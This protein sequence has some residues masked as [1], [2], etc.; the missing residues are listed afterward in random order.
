MGARV[1]E[2]VEVAEGDEAP[3]DVG[4]RLVGVEGGLRDVLAEEGGKLE[5]EGHDVTSRSKQSERGE[6]NCCPIICW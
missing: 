2:G 1:V 6:V 5:I 3:D 4:A